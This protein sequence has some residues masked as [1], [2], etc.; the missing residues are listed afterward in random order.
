MREW[1]QKNA[2]VAVTLLLIGLSN[3]WTYVLKPTGGLI[4]LVLLL[5]TWGVAL[6]GH[7]TFRHRLAL[8]AVATGLL[9]LGIRSGLHLG[10]VA[11]NCALS[12]CYFYLARCFWDW[13][14]SWR[15]RWEALKP[16]L[17]RFRLTRPVISR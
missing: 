1:P 2:L 10:G 11:L 7:T 17:E 6:Q 8:L 3:W 15:K 4:G 13:P 5:V 14:A 16:H 9:L 12:G